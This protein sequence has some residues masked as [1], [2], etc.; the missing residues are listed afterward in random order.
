ML[1]EEVAHYTSVHCCSRQ[2]LLQ[3][4]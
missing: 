2:C 3:T 4:W 1:G